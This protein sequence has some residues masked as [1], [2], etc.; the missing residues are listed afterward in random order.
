MGDEGDDRKAP[1]PAWLRELCYFGGLIVVLAAFLFNQKS[2]IRS[3]REEQTR[4]SQDIAAIR[5]SL[6]NKEV[7]D[8]RLSGITDKIAEL[9][10]DL[11]VEKLKHQNLRER[12]IKKGWAE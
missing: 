9:R 12:L 11:E 2:D 3:A 10:Q 6:P 4:I 8:L 7:Y 5:Q 1:F